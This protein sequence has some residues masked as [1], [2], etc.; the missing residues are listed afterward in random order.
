MESKILGERIRERRRK[1]KMSMDE[2]GAAIG[3]DS[4]GRKTAVHYIE[5]GTNRLRIERLHAVAAA[6]QTSIYY[7]LGII[8]DDSITDDDIVMLINNR[9]LDE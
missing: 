5:V 6:L 7:L 3:F 2:L 4:S 1:Q 8:D 9:S